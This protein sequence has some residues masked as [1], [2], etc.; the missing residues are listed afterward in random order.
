MFDL[1]VSAKKKAKKKVSND[2][3]HVALKACEQI[4]VEDDLVSI[5][6]NYLRSAADKAYRILHWCPANSQKRLG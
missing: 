6:F 1:I 2:S 4:E 3:I 5:K